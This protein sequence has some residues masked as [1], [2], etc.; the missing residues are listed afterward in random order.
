MARATAEREALLN[1]PARIAA[2]LAVKFGAPQRDVF[3]ALD[4][5]V[6]TYLE[7]R[8]RTPVPQPELAPCSAMDDGGA[9]AYAAQVE[10]GETYDAT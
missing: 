7:E 6:R 5:A 4:A 8:S 3:M 2:G 9:S 1:W 10:T